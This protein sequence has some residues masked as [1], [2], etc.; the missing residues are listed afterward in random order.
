MQLNITGFTPKQTRELKEAVEFF[1]RLLGLER[2]SYQLDIERNRKLDVEGEC[3]DEDGTKNPRWFT[4]TLRGKRDDDPMIRTLAHE[5]VHVKQYIRNQLGKQ[6]TV[7]KGGGFK[8]AT[9]WEGE[10]WTPAKHEDPY[11]DSPWEVE[12]YGREIGMFHRWNTRS[13]S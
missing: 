13:S 4:I 8:I 11:F 12:A 7:T 6:M 9:K 2:I 1:N 3:A 10:Y 5:M